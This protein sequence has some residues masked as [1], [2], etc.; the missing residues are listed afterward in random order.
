MKIP[1]L[2]P[3]S[4]SFPFGPLGRPITSNEESIYE[5]APVMFGTGI[6]GA[7]PIAETII[8]LDLNS[9]PW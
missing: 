3:L 4:L 9:L 7:L 1:D 6:D 5:S 2:F 8:S